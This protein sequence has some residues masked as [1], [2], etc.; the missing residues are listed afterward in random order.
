MPPGP[1]HLPPTTSGVNLFIKH[2]PYSTSY[3]LPSSFC[4]GS[5]ITKQHAGV[6]GILSRNSPY[7]QPPDRRA[8]RTWNNTVAEEALLFHLLPFR[9]LRGT[10]ASCRATPGNAAAPTALPKLRLPD[11]THY[12]HH[13]TL[14]AHTTSGTATP[15]SQPLRAPFRTTCSL[16]GRCAQGGG[17]APLL[18]T[19]A[20]TPHT[21]CTHCTHLCPRTLPAPLNHPTRFPAR[22]L[23]Y[24]LQFI[25]PGYT[26]AWTLFLQWWDLFRRVCAGCMPAACY[27]RADPTATIPH[28]AFTYPTTTHYLPAH[29]KRT[30]LHTSLPLRWVRHATTPAKR[31][32][33]FFLT[34]ASGITAHLPPV[35][36][37][38][39]GRQNWRGPTG[40]RWRGRFR[41]GRTGRGRYSLPR[42]GSGQRFLPCGGMPN[43]A[44]LPLQLL[45]RLLFGGERC[46]SC[47]SPL[48]HH[49]PTIPHI[50]H[51]TWPLHT[52]TLGPHT[53]TPTH[54][55]H[56]TPHYP[57]TP[58]SSHTHTTTPPGC[59]CPPP[60]AWDGTC[61]RVWVMDI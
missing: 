39:E 50:P 13:P 48:P 24:H 5:I 15:S 33:F 37:V 57:S 53:H 54:H 20:P 58:Y 59:T 61:L 41:T 56:T 26:R 31:L 16:T 42:S 46:R 3:S 44:R 55:T 30:Y 36:L 14:P 11:R 4:V 49:P 17:L 51:H 52:F 27:L 10:F 38:K 9:T 34:A 8:F 29:R 19:P 47:L 45:Y 43:F 40:D 23:S 18:F 12:R 35:G 7:P 22:L 28:A 60:P 25:L 2:V 1:P 21:R 32:F 6:G